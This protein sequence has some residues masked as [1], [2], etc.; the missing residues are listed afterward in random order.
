MT[1]V[2]RVNFKVCTSCWEF[3]NQYM[4]GADFNYSRKQAITDCRLCKQAMCADCQASSQREL[5]DEP[6]AMYG[7]T[8]CQPCT[9]KIRRLTTAHT[10]YTEIAIK[11]MEEFKKELRKDIY[12]LTQTKYAVSDRHL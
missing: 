5:K 8:L 3:H 1:L 2:E 4:K 9:N 10:I 12:H 6:L 11:K 7:F